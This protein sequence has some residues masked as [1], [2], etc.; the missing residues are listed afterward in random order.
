MKATEILIEEHRIITRVLACLQ[1]I[2]TEAEKSGKLNADSARTAV[3]FFRNFAD[4]CHHAKEE[5][6]LF[7]VMEEQGFPRQGGPIGVML[8]EHDEGRAAVRGMAQAIEK[9]AQ[10]DSEALKKFTDCAREFIPLLQNH[11][12]KEDQVLFPMADQSL[13]SKADSL[14]ADFRQIE[15]DAGGRRHSCYAKIA[16][17]LCARYQIEFLEGEDLAT[18]RTEFS[19]D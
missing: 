4:G 1:E 8:Y 18:L 13:G 16:R 7:V 12:H 5:D 3:D 17:D 14:L 9:A 15:Q 2:V 11:I 19:I 10:G 6:R